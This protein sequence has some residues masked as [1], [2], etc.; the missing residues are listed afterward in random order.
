VQAAKKMQTYMMASIMLIVL[1]AIGSIYAWRTP[2]DIVPQLAILQ[3]AKPTPVMAEGETS[4][5]EIVVE[6]SPETVTISLAPDD[7]TLPEVNGENGE[8]LIPET[9]ADTAPE[10]V[11]EDSASVSAAKIGPIA[12]STDITSD[13]QAIDPGQRFTEGYFTLYATFNYEGMDD[14]S[15]WSWLWKHNGQAID[16]GEQ[17]WSY[18]VNGPGYVYFQPEQGFQLGEHS[19]ELWV[20]DQLMSQSNFSISEGVSASN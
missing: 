8:S 6:A 19:L 16:G 17:Q 12:F 5:A 1:I 4:S 14:V 10:P 18:G 11:L 2:E 13:Y 15:T 3:N 9:V 20:G 7:L